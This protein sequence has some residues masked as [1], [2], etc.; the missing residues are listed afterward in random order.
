[1]HAC[2][3]DLWNLLAFKCLQVPTFFHGTVP[4]WGFGSSTYPPR[5]LAIDEIFAP[6]RAVVPHWSGGS[7]SP[8][9]GKQTLRGWVICSPVRNSCSLLNGGI[10]SP[11]VYF[12][13]GSTMGLGHVGGCCDRALPFSWEFGPRTHAHCFLSK[14]YN[15][16]PG[17]LIS[18]PP[19]PA[20]SFPMGCDPLVSPSWVIL[21]FLLG[22]VWFPQLHLPT[23]FPRGGDA[24]SSCPPSH[25]GGCILVSPTTRRSLSGDAVSPFLGIWFSLPPF[26]RGR[27]HIHGVCKIKWYPDLRRWNSGYCQWAFRVSIFSFRCFFLHWVTKPTPLCELV[28]G[29]ST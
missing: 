25:H 4:W 21:P 12:W 24:K 18:A 20:P 9:V 22:G 5:H 8:F 19:S 13:I 10:W 2:N 15:L 28:M 17:D 29:G 1:M 14:G 11:P 26:L 6:W 7:Y 27:F 23:L 3:F 16:P